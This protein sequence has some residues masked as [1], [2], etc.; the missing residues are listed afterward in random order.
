[1]DKS[2]TWNLPER[3]WINIPAK[4][5]PLGFIPWKQHSH[6]G[7]IEPLQWKDIINNN[8]ICKWTSMT[9]SYYSVWPSFW[10][11]KQFCF[12]LIAK[13]HSYCF[14]LI[15]KYFCFLSK[16]K[17]LGTPFSLTL[18]TSP[19][20]PQQDLSTYIQLLQNI[21]VHSPNNSNFIWMKFGTNLGP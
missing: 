2:R 14:L 5:R 11:E 15:A 19:K 3:K 20:F 1:M 4:H 21:Q 13:W 8:G 17:S 12:L 7:T 16:S 9:Y 6:F 18:L 10:K